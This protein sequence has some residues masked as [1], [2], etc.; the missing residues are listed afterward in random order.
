MIKNL[1]EIC[2]LMLNIVQTASSNLKRKDPLA[3]ASRS[4]SVSPLA[5]KK[6]EL[7]YF[8]FVFFTH[9]LLFLDI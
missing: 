2:V 8:L 6:K 9:R 5:R 3:Q 1:L 4:E 7:R